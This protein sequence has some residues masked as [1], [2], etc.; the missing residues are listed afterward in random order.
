MKQEEID[1]LKRKELE[2]KKVLKMLESDICQSIIFDLFRDY[3]I[4]VCHNNLLE[5][6]DKLQNY[7]NSFGEAIK[8]IYIETYKFDEQIVNKA[9]EQ[10]KKV[11]FEQIKVKPHHLIFGS[12]S[13]IS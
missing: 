3:L 7:L 10:Y 5:I 12:N 1:E 4:R 13:L 2:R 6:N 9:I 11:L 8:P